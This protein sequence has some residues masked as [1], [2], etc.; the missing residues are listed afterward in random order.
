VNSGGNIALLPTPTG[1]TYTVAANG[2]ALIF[3]GSI[4]GG[5][6]YLTKQNTGLML[7]FDYG[8]STGEFMP[9]SAGI[10]SAASISG[11][12][13]ASQAPGGSNQSPCSSGIATSTGNGTLITTMDINSGAFTS[14]LQTSGTLTTGPLVSGRIMDT[15]Y[16]VIY[17]VSPGYFLMLNY[18]PGNY[19]SVIHIFEQ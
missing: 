6:W 9:Q 8:V 17:V 16:N 3:L 1:Y 4:A 15:N 5:K 10:L 11:N 12:Y 13:F 18:A 2:Q 7:G 14:G 19:M